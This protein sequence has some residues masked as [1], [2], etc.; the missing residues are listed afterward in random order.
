MSKSSKM[1]SVAASRIQ[2]STAKQN[3]GS[4]SSNSFAARAQSSSSK[5]SATSKK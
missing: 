5:G 2:A 3:G 4:V 1:S